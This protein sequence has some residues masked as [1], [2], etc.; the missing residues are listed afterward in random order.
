VAPTTTSTAITTTTTTVPPASVTVLVL[1]GWTTYHAA[2]F[3]QHKLA[4][5]GYDTRAP[6]NAISSTNAHSQIFFSSPAYEANALA[7]AKQ[8][9][10][11][12]SA[13]AAPVA[14]NDS[15]V[16]VSDLGQQDLI[17]VV[18]GDISGQVPAGYS[19]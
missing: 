6:N 16:P 19:G 9:G 12:K 1:N 14:A 13:V 5:E 15:A 10:L 17:L 2:A 11:P 18:G 4:S 3:F 7:I 8:L